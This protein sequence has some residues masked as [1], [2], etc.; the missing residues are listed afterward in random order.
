MVLL[1]HADRLP[2]RS[3]RPV[4][5]SRAPPHPGGL[6]LIMLCP[7]MVLGGRPRQYGRTFSCPA[8]RT[9]IAGALFVPSPTCWWDHRGRA[10]RHRLDRK[11]QKRGGQADGV[12]GEGGRAC[13]R[14]VLSLPAVEGRRVYPRPVLR[15]LEESRPITTRMNRSMVSIAHPGAK[16][17]PERSAVSAWD[18]SV[19]V[20]AQ[21]AKTYAPLLLRFFSRVQQNAQALLARKSESHSTEPKRAVLPLKP[22][23]PRGWLP[24]LATLLAC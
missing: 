10:Q 24:S 9:G 19:Q 11:P 1:E 16:V 23:T 2:T 12:S 22:V 5:S 14:P 13:G 20:V 8:A 6:R 18:K 7:G 17:R 3:G 4:F 21:Q 15:F